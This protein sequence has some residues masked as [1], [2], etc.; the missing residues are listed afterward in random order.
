M[1][2]IKKSIFQMVLKEE[3]DEARSFMEKWIQDG[4]MR[5]FFKLE[6]PRIKAMSSGKDSG[7]NV[8]VTV[9]G[10]EIEFNTNG[11]GTQRGINFAVVD[12]V[13]HEVLN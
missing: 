9:N 3:I 7:S 13:T 4:Y 8:M 5:S 12:P 10:H 11:N 2:S 1:N 6:V